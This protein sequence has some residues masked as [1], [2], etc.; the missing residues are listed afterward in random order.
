MYLEWMAETGWLKHEKLDA[1]NWY[2]SLYNSENR[3]L[4]GLAPYEPGDF[5]HSMALSGGKFLQKWLC[6]F[7]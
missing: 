2:V 5:G 3:C 6:D 1:Y 4:S 7:C